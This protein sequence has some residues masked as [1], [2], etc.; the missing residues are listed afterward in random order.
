M[1]KKNKDFYNSKETNETKNLIG[2]ILISFFSCITTYIL[3]TNELLVA[4]QGNMLVVALVVFAVVVI[5]GLGFGLLMNKIT[6]G[7]D[8]DET[9]YVDITK[10]NK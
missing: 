2:Y 1:M 10:N 5:F 6:R 9:G 8:F 4:L 3:L 7:K